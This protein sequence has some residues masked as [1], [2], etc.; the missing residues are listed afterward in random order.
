MLEIIFFILVHLLCPIQYN[1]STNAE[2]MNT[3]KKF[4]S[5]QNEH[6]ACYTWCHTCSKRN[7]TMWSQTA[8]S[9]QKTNHWPLKIIETRSWE[10]GFVVIMSHL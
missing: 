9:K 1:N 2:N 4:V 8:G 10:W 6:N 7:N 3:L 5:I